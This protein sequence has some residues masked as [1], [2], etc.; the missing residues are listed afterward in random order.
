MPHDLVRGQFELA[1]RLYRFTTVV[2]DTA[3]L[4][5]KLP[6]SLGESQQ[7]AAARYRPRA[8]EIP[9]VEISSPL[10]DCVG[11]KSVYD[12]SANGFSFLIDGARDLYPIGL[13]VD[14]S[15]RLPDGALA[16]AAEV[17][18]LVRDGARLRCGV[19]RL[20]LDAVE[21]LRL[22]NYVMHLRFPG[23][24]DGG[25]LVP[26]ELFPFFR[27]TGFLPPEKEA[28]SAPV[29]DELRESYRSLYAQPSAVFK[30]V[31]SRDPEGGLVG[32]VSGVRAYSRTWMS[33]HLAAQPS[34]H[35]AHLLNL[36]AA[37][38]FGQNPDL[39]FFKIY[40]DSYNK[41][42]ARVFGGFARML[43][44]SQQSELRSY[45]HVVL[46]TAQTLP[47]PIGID[48]LEASTDDLGIVEGHFL[49][50][51]QT[52]LLRSDDLT[53]NT[54][55]LSGLN[56]RFGDV[57]LYRR[58]RVLLAMR[59]NVCLGFAL[60]ELSSPGLNLSEALSAFRIFVTDE[61]QAAQDSVR[62]AL[63]AAVV[64]IYR[65]AGRTLAAACSRRRRSTRIVASARR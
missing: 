13:I 18:T 36:G 58:R 2:V 34:K 6:T 51:E 7:R 35:V 1:G 52:L 14:I 54:L 29:M 11:L 12:L 46:A 25:G 59:R 48:V 4:E 45:R 60:A 26:D 23:V 31:V 3:P 8:S 63:M 24:D 28:A 30:A 27:A 62:R 22:A 17:R 9:P 57:G 33:Q 61:G 5:L 53:S 10:A 32:H 65:N 16:C 47:S 21:R 19:E 20:D 41:W 42:P 37:E 55:Q 64:P 56:R 40:F 43:R 49:K 38:Y 44:D 15:L 50:H 39:E